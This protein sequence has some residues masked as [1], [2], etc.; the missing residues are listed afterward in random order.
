MRGI[1][2]QKEPA[3]LAVFVWF[4]WTLFALAILMIAADLVLAYGDDIQAAAH[5]YF[6][7]PFPPTL[8][9]TAVPP[10]PPPRKPSP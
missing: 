10:S 2:R 5:D 9:A 7:G 4:G 1:L 8:E 6:V 3:L